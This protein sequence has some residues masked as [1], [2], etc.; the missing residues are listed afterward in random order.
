MVPRLPWLLL[1]VVWL[2]I[3]EHSFK[4][5]Y[6]DGTVFLTHHFVTKFLYI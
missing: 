3:D 1:T 5:V 2:V 4:A 6:V